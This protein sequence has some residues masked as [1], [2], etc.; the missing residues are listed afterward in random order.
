M[1]FQKR[2]FRTNMSIICLSLLSLLSVIVIVMVL[3]EDAIEKRIFTMDQSQVDPHITEIQ[4]LLQGTDDFAEIQTEAEKY[5]Y[6]VCLV[7]NNAIVQGDQQEGM[8]EITDALHTEEMREGEADIY[9][10][11]NTTCLIKCTGKNSYLIACHFP[12]ENSLKTSLKDAMWMWI[13][14][15]VLIGAGAISVILLVSS[16]F[17]RKIN[18]VIMEPM[19]ELMLATDR[20]AQ[21][22]LSEPIEYIGEHEFEQV[23]NAFN[24]MQERILKNEQ[25]RIDMVTGISHDLRTPLTSIQGYIKGVLD[26]IANTEEKKREYLLTAYDS[27]LEMNVLLQKLFDFSKLE[28]GQLPSHFLKVDL[29][30]FL[31]HWTSGQNVSFTYQKDTDDLYVS[32]DIDQFRRILDNLLENSMKYAEQDP[33]EISIE[34]YRKDHKVFFAWSDNGK[35]VKEDQLDH[36]FERFYRCDEARTAK[37]SGVGLYVVKYI[38]EMHGGNVKAVNEN[39]LKLIFSFPDLEE[40][41]AEDIDR[42]R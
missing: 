23:T 34:L 17:T 31:H 15:I 12:A 4:S 1:T 27:T 20:I 16:F 35:G 14:M 24:S 33:L 5:D 8:L 22:N 25:A 39:G 30:E 21:G 13:L 6:V 11:R 37:G 36:I 26:G 3:F 19:D 32:L 7:E 41:Y 10:Y 9:Y 29:S 40:T 38:T 28:S 2:M 42:R 18:Q